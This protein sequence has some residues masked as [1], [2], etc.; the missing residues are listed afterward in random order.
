MIRRW[1]PT[2]SRSPSNKFG[3]KAYRSGCRDALGPP[4]SGQIR[5]G[6]PGLA[7]YCIRQQNGKNGSLSPGAP[8]GVKVKSNTRSLSSVQPA[9]V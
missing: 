1:C 4:G 8:L 5:R 7:D 3:C 6:K 2:R 9:G